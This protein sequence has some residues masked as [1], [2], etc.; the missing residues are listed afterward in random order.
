[1]MPDWMPKVSLRTLTTGARQ[2]VVQLALE[3]MSCSYL[4]YLSSLTPRTTVRSSLVAGAEMITFLTVAPRCTLAF[5]ASVKKPVDST[6]ISAPTEAQSSLEGSRSAKTLTVL[7]STVM[8]S[9]VE[10]ISF[11]RL[12][13]ME[14]N[15]SRCARVAGVVRSLTAT[16]SRSGLPRAVRKTLRPMRPKPLMPT[17]TAMC[18]CSLP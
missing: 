7:P 10:V 6:T 13:R 11:L 12:P 17:F 4:S 5:S 16:I 14:S 2:L 9:A 1:M 15:W 8:E 18:V 3:M